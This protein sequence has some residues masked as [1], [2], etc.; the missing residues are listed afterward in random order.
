MEGIRELKESLIRICT[1]QMDNRIAEV[2]SQLDLIEESR[3]NETRSSAGDKYETGRAMMQIEEEKLK[4]RLLEAHVIRQ[5]LRGIDPKE[6][7]RSVAVGS[8]VY[9]NSGA[10]FISVGIGKVALEKEL[11]YCISLDS[12]LGEV[13]KGS[14]EGVQLMFRGKS[15][16]V[17]GVR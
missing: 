15:I 12:P 4:T 13:L 9:T 3:N 17:N 11:F 7:F 6:E 14:T 16:V 10:Y 5:I 2:N 8:L 1:L